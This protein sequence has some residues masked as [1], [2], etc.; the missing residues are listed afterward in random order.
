MATEPVAPVGVTVAVNVT[1]P[2]NVAGEGDA[3]TVV[4]PVALLTVSVAVPAVP[5]R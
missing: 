5:V 1:E 2:P 3:D 4:V